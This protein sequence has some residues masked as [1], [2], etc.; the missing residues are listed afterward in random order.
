MPIIDFRDGFSFG[1]PEFPIS[2]FGQ[3]VV[4]P[5]VITGPPAM[6]QLPP[7]PQRRGGAAAARQVRNVKRQ[8]A[9]TNALTDKLHANPISAQIPLKHPGVVD[10]GTGIPQMPAPAPLSPG[11]MQLNYRSGGAHGRRGG[12]QGAREDS[13]AANGG[14]APTNAMKARTW[15]AEQQKKINPL[16]GIGPDVPSHIRHR[17]EAT[18]DSGSPLFG[19]SMHDALDPTERSQLN[20]MGVDRRERLRNNDDFQA[21]RDRLSD[22]RDNALSLRRDANA[23][24]GQTQGAGVSFSRPVLGSGG[25]TMTQPTYHQSQL[26]LA[27]AVALSQQMK[28]QGATQE[29]KDMLGI[30]GQQLEL[31][32]MERDM[33]LEDQGIADAQSAEITNNAMTSSEGDPLAA[34]AR[35]AVNPSMSPEEKAEAVARLGVSPAELQVYMDEGE[36]ILDPSLANASGMMNQLFGAQAASPGMS[37]PLLMSNLLGL[38]S[39]GKGDSKIRKEQESAIQQLIEA[40]NAMSARNGSTR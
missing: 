17:I 21:Y 8:I 27:A 26:P 1:A 6:P 20:Q 38:M 25:M 36:P 28:K 37:A 10:D 3:Q 18:E 16:L 4:R 14:L 24:R 33:G 23:L 34:A 11:Q 2:R 15:A 31:Q 9:A 5:P 19:M 32:K 22:R 7:P 39:E 13:I 12:E 30:K 35:I 29:M 40:L